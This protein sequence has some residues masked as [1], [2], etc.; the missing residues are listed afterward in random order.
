MSVFEVYED[1]AEKYRWRLKA[2]NNEIVAVS[3]AYV[4][5]QSAIKSANRVKQIAS[6]A[7]IVDKTIIIRLLKQILKK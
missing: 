1:K 4:Y 3:E 7:T 6:S 5:K 2:N